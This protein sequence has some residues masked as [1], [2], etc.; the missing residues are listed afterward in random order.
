MF[1]RPWIRCG[2]IGIEVLSSI[3]TYSKTVGI[4]EVGKI[5]E[6][7]YYEWTRLNLNI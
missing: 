6:K 5:I 2:R 1:E 4:D 7:N 3:E